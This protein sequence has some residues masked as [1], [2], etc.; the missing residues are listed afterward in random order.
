M[1]KWNHSGK[2]K[3][4]L[5]VIQ[6]DK[7]FSCSLEHFYIKKDFYKFTPDAIFEVHNIDI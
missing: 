6:L 1:I 3:M 5:A 2:Y 7:R 4:S